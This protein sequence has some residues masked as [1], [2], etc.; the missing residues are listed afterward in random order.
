MG[1]VSVVPPGPKLALNGPGHKYAYLVKSIN[2][3]QVCDVLSE[4]LCT[5]L[6]FALRTPTGGRP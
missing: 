1:S 6:T 2:F 4:V 3:T 5:N